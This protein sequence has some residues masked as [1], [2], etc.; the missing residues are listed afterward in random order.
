MHFSFY[1][2]S[3]RKKKFLRLITTNSGNAQHTE[4][5]KVPL[6]LLINKVNCYSSSIIVLHIKKVT[7]KKINYGEKKKMLLSQS[8]QGEIFFF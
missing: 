3:H 8:D 4:K 6:A 2:Q 5:I 7:E 1:S